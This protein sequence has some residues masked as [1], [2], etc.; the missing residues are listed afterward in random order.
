[1]NNSPTKRE[2]YSKKE[3]EKQTKLS[4]MSYKLNSKCL[5][6]CLECVK[7]KEEKKKKKKECYSFFF[8]E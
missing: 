7:E 1:M 5:W 4:G 3:E 2:I 8:F 6:H